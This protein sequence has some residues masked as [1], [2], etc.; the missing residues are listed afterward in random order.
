M[1]LFKKFLAVFIAAVMMICCA[2]VT[3]YA[4]DSNNNESSTAQT[5]N[6]PPVLALVSGKEITLDSGT[7]SMVSFSFNVK[8]GVRISRCEFV[9]SGGNNDITI[10]DPEMTLDDLK[11]PATFTIKISKTAVSATHNLTLA[12]TSYASDGVTS[13]AQTFPIKLKV[14]SKLEARGLTIDSYKVS[15]DVVNPG[16]AF[17]ITVTLKNE[18][19][20]DIKNAEL[21]IEGLSD[22][23]FVLD[24]GA[25]KQYVNLKKG[26]IGKVTYSLIAQKGIT[27]VRETIKLKLSYSLDPSKTDLSS[28]TSTAIII[29]C[30]PK[31]KVESNYTAFDIA[32]TNYTVSSD[33]VMEDTRFTL[34]I[35]LK[36]NGSYDIEKARV[37]LT[38]D[39]KKFS[40]NS[41]LGFN[42]FSLKKGASKRFTFNLIGCAGIEAE[43]ETIPVVITYG[44]ISNTLNATISCVPKKT[45]D[46]KA[47]RDLTVVSYSTDVD[48][49]YESTIFNL[50]VDVKNSSDHEIKDARI[51]LNKLDGTKFAIDGGLPFV[52]F[53]IASG[54]TKG[55]VFRLVGCG[56]IA[57]IRE[58][59]EIQLDFEKVS[60][61]TNA[62]I[63]CH[64]KEKE[65]DTNKV[66]APNIII[67]NYTY[68]GQE[69][70]TAGKE[71]PL[72]ITIKNVSGV[73]DIENLKVTVTGASLTA[74]NEA[75]VAYSPSN[76][77]NT[78][79]F[80]RLNVL[81]SVDISMKMLSLATAKP[82]SYP[83]SIDFVYEYTVKDQ[84]YKSDKVQETIS[85]PLRQEDRVSINEVDVPNG[86]IYTNQQ[87]TVSTS[88]INKG[89][90]D[91]YNVNVSVSGDD[92]TAE[93]NSYYIGNIKSGAEEFYDVKLMPLSAGSGSGSLK[94]TY[95]DANGDEKE[96]DLPFT[97]NVEELMIEDFGMNMMPEAPVEEGPNFLLIGGIALA[98]V[99]VIIIVIVVIVK[100]VKKKKSEIVDD[101]DN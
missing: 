65:T 76:S 4:E 2:A 45:E 8:N 70:V 74:G 73:S 89:K 23:K 60:N 90:S 34:T 48:T 42:D 81:S 38:T 96:T 57:S 29:D 10:M 31:E 64:P 47:K 1:V 37:G 9:L 75:T 100:H 44:S 92:F 22:E 12:V 43:R 79:F 94:I 63:K 36:N 80:D 85:I 101:E 24:K 77:S 62:T 69:Y 61:T 87:F 6:V 21:E 40:I 17:D 33:K 27:L 26:E 59:V 13:N 55:F 97:F 46:E 56:G 28:S 84:R 39:G 5:S 53:D 86:G 14:V 82:N 3:V 58:V 41:G 99:I 11:S 91:I 52:S 35:D 54:A 32:M 83:I 20:I 98:A 72:N 51:T 93:S 16:D 88:I 66:I 7:S 25:L 68:G 78:F 67:E 71:F 19:G 15:K 50:Y 30:N 18:T 95:E 49:V